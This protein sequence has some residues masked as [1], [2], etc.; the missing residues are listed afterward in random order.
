MLAR[1]YILLRESDQAA[2]R[3]RLQAAVSAWS[4]S[5][6]AST[7]DSVVESFDVLASPEQVSGLLQETAGYWAGET[8]AGNVTFVGTADVPGLTVAL[9][10]TSDRAANVPTV[11]EGEL[12][13]RCMTDLSH[14]LANGSEPR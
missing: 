13:S 1:P 4:T 7:G 3:G 12:L 10:G 14:R 6:F 11:L 2:V 5:W 9:L 8:E